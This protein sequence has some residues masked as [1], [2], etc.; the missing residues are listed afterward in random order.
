MKR[1]LILLLV[2]AIFVP[3]LSAQR[4]NRGYTFSE[5]SVENGDSIATIHILPVRTYSRKAD[6]RRYARMIRAVKKVYPIS[7]E[8]K[9][10]MALMEA[11]LQSLPSKEDQELYT[12]GIQKR[13]VKEYT[14][15][16]KRMTIY[17]GKILLKLID[18]E[19]EHTAFQIIKEFRG[20]FVAGFWQALAKLFG[21]NLKVDYDPEGEDQMLHRIVTMYERGLL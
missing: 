21:N 16:L 17:E 12:K 13:I 1:L 19:T 9:R 10:E 3:S 11:E 20:G 4:R 5:W 18:R 7:Q 8:A 2:G 6:M 15:V 14:P